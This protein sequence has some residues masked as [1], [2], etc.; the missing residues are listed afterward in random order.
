[1]NEFNLVWDG[2]I[3]LAAL[4]FIASISMN[5][6]CFLLFGSFLGKGASVNGACLINPKTLSPRY[7]KLGGFGYL[8]VIVSEAIGYSELFAWRG[9]LRRNIPFSVSVFFECHEIRC[10]GSVYELVWLDFEAITLW[11]LSSKP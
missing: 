2:L 7:S 9:N 10:A 8:R 5:V 1:M 3:I 6:D 4:T 11:I